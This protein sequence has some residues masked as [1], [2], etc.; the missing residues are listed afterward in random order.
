MH[1]GRVGP[2]VSRAFPSVALRR[3]I[4]ACVGIRALPFPPT[5]V[6]TY[7]SLKVTADT[8]RDAEARRGPLLIRV[9]RGPELVRHSNALKLQVPTYSSPPLL[10][11]WRE[12]GGF[13]S[14]NLRNRSQTR[15]SAAVRGTSLAALRFFEC[16]SS[17]LPFCW[18]RSSKLD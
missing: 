15:K 11:G 4:C 6:A 1:L 7:I 2:T 13:L 8:S 18:Q 16:I 14:L 9:L 10:I 3:E 17:F 12:A 5:R